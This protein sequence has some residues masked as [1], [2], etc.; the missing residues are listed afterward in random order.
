MGGGAVYVATEAGDGF[1][2][3]IHLLT[4]KRRWHVRAGLIAAPLVLRDTTLYAVTTAGLLLALD[5][6]TG[7]TRWSRVAGASRGGALVTASSRGASLSDSLFLLRPR[8][9]PRARKG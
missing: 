5:T 7:A 6:R 4:G 2:T 8:G 9:A 3:A 1:V